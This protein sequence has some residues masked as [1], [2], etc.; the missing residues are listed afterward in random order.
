MGNTQMFKD[1]EIKFV[2]IDTQSKHSALK[3]LKPGKTYRV[4]A[5]M[6][7]ANPAR[8]DG[9]LGATILSDK[10]IVLEDEK[11]NL[12]QFV[13]NPEV[14]KIIHNAPP[15]EQIERWMKARNKVNHIYK[16]RVIPGVASVVNGEFTLGDLEND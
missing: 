5:G 6:G 9:K 13:F 11:G 7:N 15:T 1:S 16:P 8:S 12:S 14:F 10:L 4:I 2:G 3:R